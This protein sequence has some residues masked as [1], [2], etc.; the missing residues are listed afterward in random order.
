MAGQLRRVDG[1]GIAALALDGVHGDVGIAQQVGHGLAVAR[2]QR[3]ADAGRD[4]AFLSADEDGLAQGIQHALG[5]ALGIALV[6]HFGQ[7]GDELVAAQAAHCLQ[8]AVAAVTHAVEHAFQDLVGMAHAA[9]QAPA[10]L[11]EEF[12][13]GRVT[14]R[15][16]DDLEAVQVDQ[17]QA[18]LVAAAAGA[19]DGSLDAVDELAAVRQAGQGVEMGELADAVLG[20]AAVGHVLQDAGVAVHRSLLVELWLGLDVDD[21]L[22]AVGQGQRQVG[23]EHGGVG[24]DVAQ[25]AQEDVAVVRRHHAHDADEVQTVLRAAAED[26]QALGGDGEAGRRVA[27]P[28]EAAH[29]RQVLG[30]GQLGLA[31]LQFEARARAAQQIAQ[32]AVQQAPLR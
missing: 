13:A 31:A 4:E 28:L 7:Q 21:A 27:P 26:A 32:A 12:V 6:S 11:D 22:A 23:D 3:N 25:Q 14:Q 2:I 8:A 30:A 29:A 16:V 20:L 24:N 18:D 5:D 19:L 9:A 1:R 10:D 17:Q 15:V